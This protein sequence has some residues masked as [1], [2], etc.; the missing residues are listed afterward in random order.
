ML[1]EHIMVALESLGLSADEPVLDALVLHAGMMLATNAIHNL[2]RITDEEDVA[3]LHVAD[4]L[5]ALP[6]LVAAP[7]GS[8]ADIG[9]GAGYP[10]IPLA[11]LSARHAVLVESRAKKAAFLQEAVDVLGI[12]AEVRMSRAEELAESQ[13]GAFGAVTARALATLPSLVE[14]AAPLLVV[15]GT[16]IALKGEPGAEEYASGDAV[17]RIVGLK[18]TSTDPVTI[19]GVDLQRTIVCYRRERESRIALPRRPGMAQKKPLA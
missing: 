14:L 10:G 11:L 1:R 5:T 9:S 19:P 8:F 12:D 15:G 2:T 16:L 13:A 3:L 18:R 17:A 7:E 6:Y 4:S